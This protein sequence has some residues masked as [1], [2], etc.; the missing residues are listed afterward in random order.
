MTAVE[1]GRLGVAARAVGVSR[2]ASKTRRLRQGA[3][4]SAT[5]SPTSRSSSR[6]HR[7]G[8]RRQTARL[9][10]RDATR[11]RRRA[12]PQRPRWPRCT[13]PTSPS[14]PPAT[15]PDLRR[16]RHLARPPGRPHYRDAK[17]LQ[18]VEGPTTCT[19]PSSPRWRSAPARASP[20]PGP[21]V[22]PGRRTLATGKLAL[23]SAETLESSNVS[24]ETDCLSGAPVTGGERRKVESGS[25]SGGRTESSP[26]G[27][28]R[29]SIPAWRPNLGNFPPEGWRKVERRPWEWESS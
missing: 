15:P 9:F 29:T 24:A 23:V 25:R 26:C 28:P 1:R 10:V 8:G 2:P 18:I 19:G 13:P 6:S 12:R 17:V 20:P 21:T 27:H 16:R 7:H 5:R 3:G 11:C 4:R 22:G 14:A